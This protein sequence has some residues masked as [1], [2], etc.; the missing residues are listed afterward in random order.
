MKKVSILLLCFIYTNCLE[1]SE[2]SFP[3]PFEFDT[4]LC[5]SEDA[6]SAPTS[7]PKEFMN[8][9]DHTYPLR[10]IYLSDLLTSTSSWILSLLSSTPTPI[11]VDV[12]KL[13]V[14]DKNSDY[15]WIGLGQNGDEKEVNTY[16]GWIAVRKEAVS[17]EEGVIQLM[18][19]MLFDIFDRM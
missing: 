15:A 3:I 10:A 2:N 13:I 6:A 1:L 5:Y 19:M 12:A 4:T 18:R 8:Y 14:A 17:G 11:T 16:F 9:F 7:L